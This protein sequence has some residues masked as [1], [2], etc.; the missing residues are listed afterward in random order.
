MQK[1]RVYANVY[2]LFSIDNLS[3]YDIDPEINEDNGLQFP[4]SQIFNI[5]VNLSF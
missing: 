4:Q 5:G 2:N 3:P 1:A